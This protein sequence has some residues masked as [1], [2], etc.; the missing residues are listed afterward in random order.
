MALRSYREFHEG[1]PTARDESCADLGGGA[2]EPPEP[3]RDS[4]EPADLAGI[5]RDLIAGKLRFEKALA[6]E[7][8]HY[9]L[10]ARGDDAP[11]LNAR[12][13]TMVGRVLGGEQQKAVA[14]EEN[15]ACSTASKWFTSGLKKLG[16]N[17]RSVPLPLVLAAQAGA[18]HGAGAVEA[19]SHVRRDGQA[20]ILLSVPK[21]TVGAKVLTPTEREVAIKLAEGES[22]WEI[23]SSRV[24]SAQTV[25]CQL[26]GVY[27]KLKA[28]GRYAVVK[29]GREMGWFAEGSSTA[30]A[31][32]PSKV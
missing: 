5:W 26:R 2:R 9:V 28:T 31:P 8:R 3:P 10:L 6:D 27:S 17:R 13:T 24:K 7:G 20:R 18:G 11:Q 1:R 23:A 22:R 25:A 30:I 15:I 12:E 21:P 19:R 16:L 4:S 29:R 32:A 14:Y